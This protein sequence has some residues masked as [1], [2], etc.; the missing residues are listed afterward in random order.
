[1]TKTIP[2]KTAPVKFQKKNIFF[3]DEGKGKVIVLL[4]GFTESSKIWTG[5]ASK[6]SEKYRVIT[7]DLPGHGKSGR[8]AKIHTMELMADVVC[9][10][11]KKAGIGKSLMI[12]HSMGGYLTLAFAEKYPKMLKG[13]GLFNSHCFA[14]TSEDI[15]NRDRTIAIVEKDKFSF[16]A[17]FI[18]GLFPVEVHKLFAKQIERLVQRASKMDKESVIAA[19]E[20]MKVRKDQTELLKTTNLPVLFILGLKDSKAPLTK[21]WEMVSLPAKSEILLLRDC[22]HM[23]YIEA[24]EATFGA[25][26]NFAK[27]NL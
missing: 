12:G 22:G 2:L 4:H 5:F 26:M 13:I 11:L 1:M 23:G 25:V 21:L 9:A 14:D 15:S 19:L 20:G 24:P 6:L 7:I 10:V 16:V 8:V 18:P 17:Q 3:T 27:S